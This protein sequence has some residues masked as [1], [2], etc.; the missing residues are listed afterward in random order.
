MCDED[1]KDGQP[2]M[3]PHRGAGGK[4]ASW[5][6]SRVRALGLH[7]RRGGGDKRGEEV[8]AKISLKTKRNQAGS[9]AHTHTQ[10]A[11]LETQ[12]WGQVAGHISLA[13]AGSLGRLYLQGVMGISLF[14]GM[15]GFFFDVFVGEGEHTV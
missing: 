4:R 9:R 2:S 6:L 11:F 12:L 15:C 13:G 3:A 7:C 8:C 5:P 1:A 14:S 10:T